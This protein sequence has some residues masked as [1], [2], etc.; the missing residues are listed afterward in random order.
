M[1]SRVPVSCLPFS[2]CI[3]CVYQ[4]KIETTTEKL[5]LKVSKNYGTTTRGEISS[6]PIIKNHS[7][8]FYL[9]PHDDAFDKKVFKQEEKKNWSMFTALYIHTLYTILVIFIWREKNYIFR[10]RYN[11]YRNMY[12]NINQT[13][14]KRDYV[15]LQ[16]L[17]FY[18]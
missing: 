12:L 10:D 1:K 5:L 9:I 13:N 16:E 4:R 7:F 2:L 3:L 17:R 11:S 6:E 15:F 18:K 8:Q 14:I